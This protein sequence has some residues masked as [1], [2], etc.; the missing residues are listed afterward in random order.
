MRKLFNLVFIICIYYQTNASKIDEI[1]LKWMKTHYN[2]TYAGYTDDYAIEK[3]PI[4]KN[5]NCREYNCVD[6]KLF[7]YNME[8][9]WRNFYS[10]GNTYSICKSKIKKD[11][12]P[13]EIFTM[14]YYY[15]QC[16]KKGYEG[17][18]DI[19]KQQYNIKGRFIFACPNACNT[20][21]CDSL[22]HT[23]PDSC[24]PKGSGVHKNDYDCSCINETIWS[25]HSKKCYI[26]NRCKIDLCNGNACVLDLYSDNEKYTC[27]CGEKTMGKRCDE[28][29]NACKENYFKQYNGDDQC[30]VN[31]GT[32]VAYLGLNYYTCKCK[33]NFTDDMKHPGFPNCN[34]R[35][36]PCASII[37]HK[38]YCKIPENDGFNI[39]SGYCECDEGWEGEKCNKKS[40]IW[41]PWTEWTPCQ[42]E[43]GQIRTKTRKRTCS[44]DISKC[45]QIRKNIDHIKSLNGYNETIYCPSEPCKINNDEST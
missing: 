39:P 37:C 4:N 36:D 29:R 15:I 14:L 7:T 42:P 10:I 5:T 26:Q 9:E 20:K 2:D 23:I 43:C 11:A 35:I 3:N 24:V 1:F 25:T 40:P 12:D 31:N 13:G 27:E 28:P 16:V 17:E 41:L 8:C 30:K 19:L 18:V 33:N 22:S 21:K 45:L 38:G 44:E 34:K 32:C 6:T